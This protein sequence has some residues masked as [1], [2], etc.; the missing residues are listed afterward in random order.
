MLTFFRVKLILFIKPADFLSVELLRPDFCSWNLVCAYFSVHETC[1]LI[2]LPWHWFVLRTHCVLIFVCFWHLLWGGVCSWH[3]LHVDF[4]F[5]ETDV[6]QGTCCALIIV[7]ETCCIWIFLRKTCCM[8]IFLFVKL[9][10]WFFTSWNCFCS[11][12]LLR[13]DFIH[14]ACFVL[15]FFSR[16]LV[17]N[18]FFFVKLVRWF[19]SLWN[20]FLSM[21]IVSCWF[22]L[23][24]LVTW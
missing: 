14:G 12:T 19:F 20:W 10:L 3:L 4:H 21:D 18:F 2:F 23:M 8:F 6:G 22:L 11:W 5:C 1:S 7:L 9:V 13:V 15:K 17:F 24:K 16:I